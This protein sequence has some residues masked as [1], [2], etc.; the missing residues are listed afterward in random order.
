MLQQEIIR[1]KSSSGQRPKTLQRKHDSVRHC[2]QSRQD[3]SSFCNDI[4][5]EIR[6]KSGD[7]FVFQ[8]DGA[9]SRRAKWTVEFLQ[10]TM[11]N[12]TEPSVWPPTARTWTWLTTLYEGSVAEHVSHSDFQFGR[13]QGQ[14]AHLL[15]ESWPT[16]HR[17]VY[18]SVA[19]QTEG[20]GSSEWWTHWTV[21][22][23]ICFIYCCALLCSVCVLRTCMRL[24]IMCWALLW[25]CDT[26]YTWHITTW[27]FKIMI[28]C[29]KK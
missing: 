7:H 1:R 29:D 20:C 10:R 24:A 28:I 4:L 21:V 5:P 17:Q 3:I 27:H 14:C 12:F 9:Q 15:G 25:Y 6:Q 2:I 19:W 16:D 26:K 13:S 11:Q 23:I 18:R 8:Q 22:L